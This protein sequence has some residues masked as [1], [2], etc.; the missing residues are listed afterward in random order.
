[1]LQVDRVVIVATGCPF[2]CTVVSRHAPDYT[3]PKSGNFAVY[4]DDKLEPTLCLCLCTGQVTHR[5]FIGSLPHNAGLDHMVINFVTLISC[6]VVDI[7]DALVQVRIIT[8]IIIQEQSNIN[9]VITNRFMC[10]ATKKNQSPARSG[11]I[12][13]QYR[14]PIGSSSSLGRESTQS[15]RQSYTW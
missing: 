2:I 11:F 5:D 15:G 3:P 12:W 14:H 7:F 6:Y 13:A 9:L 1:M 4:H 10:R 8:G